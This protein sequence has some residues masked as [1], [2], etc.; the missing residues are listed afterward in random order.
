MK[1]IKLYHKRL[2]CDTVKLM[3]E[4][5]DDGGLLESNTLTQYY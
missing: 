1:L 4:E 5:S 3:L 2:H